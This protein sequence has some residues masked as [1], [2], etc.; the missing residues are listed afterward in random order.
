MVDPALVERAKHGDR[1]AYAELANASSN[2]L[3]AIALRVLR[4]RDAAGDALQAALVE[5]WRSLPGLRDAQAFESWSYRVTLNACR[6]IRRRNRSSI[7]TF[8]LQPT[9]VAEADSELSVATRDELERAFGRLT[10]D[11]RSVLV[12]HY[13]RDLPVDEIATTLGVAPGTIKS[14]LHAARHAMRAALEAGR[15]PARSEEQR[16]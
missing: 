1:D 6:T 4:D 8:E 9:D 3:F 2:R 13:Y 15:R 11:Q 16:A 7:A 10:V 12:L 5:I 14:R